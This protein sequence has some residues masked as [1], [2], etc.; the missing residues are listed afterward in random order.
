ATRRA[1]HSASTRRDARGFRS[2]N[3]RP[4]R[5]TTIQ[6]EGG[7]GGTGSDALRRPEPGPRPSSASVSRKSMPRDYG[8][9]GQSTRTFQR[10][11]F[12]RAG[13]A[14]RG[15]GSVAS[16]ASGVAVPSAEIRVYEI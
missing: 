12:V 7:T 5:L 15:P 11:L 1:I 6:P 10:K 8:V 9:G 14:Q 13:G 4:T 3:L 2:G 16:N